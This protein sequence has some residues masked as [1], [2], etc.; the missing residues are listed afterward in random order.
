MTGGDMVLLSELPIALLPKP[1]RADA[2]ALSSH[3]IQKA[4]LPA[5]QSMVA[6]WCVPA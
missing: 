3:S 6:I 1:V 5:Q 4:A 2:A